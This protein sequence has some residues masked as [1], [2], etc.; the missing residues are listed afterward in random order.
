M[1]SESRNEEV[2]ARVLE[3]L[4]PV[5]QI[6]G[7]FLVDITFRREP[8]GWVLRVVADREGGITVDDCAWLSRRTGDLI[9]AKELIPHAY[10]LE[11]SSPGLDRALKHDRDFRW[12]LGR[13]IRV[14][15]RQ[16]QKG[17]G[18]FIGTLVEFDGST[19]KLDCGSGLI[20]ISLD[21]VAKAM[22]FVE[23]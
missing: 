16:P 2:R 7:F 3:L 14:L 8:I 1:A 10:T 18:E 17:E 15:K 22:L 19:L 6:E 13:K 20:A 12:A 11:V 4:E 5:V 23:L 9:E 21:Q